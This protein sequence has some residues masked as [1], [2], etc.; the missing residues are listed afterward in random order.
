MPPYDKPHVNISD[1]AQGRNYTSD[2]SRVRARVIQRIRDEHGPRIAREYR[3]AF[4]LSLI[5]I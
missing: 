3:E 4:D 1:L 2:N 5:H